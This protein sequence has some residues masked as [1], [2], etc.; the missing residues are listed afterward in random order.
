MKKQYQRAFW[1]AFLVGMSPLANSA[2]ESR[3]PS[4]DGGWATNVITTLSNKNKNIGALTPNQLSVLQRK[5][6]EAGIARELNASGQFSASRNLI[7]M[8]YKN[9]ASF[10]PAAALTY[11]RTFRLQAT[12]LNMPGLEDA[13]SEVAAKRVACLNSAD[14]FLLAQIERLEKQAKGEGISNDPTVKT[15]PSAE[16]LIKLLGIYSLERA[17]TLL[18]YGD[19]LYSSQPQSLFVDTENSKWSRHAAMSKYRQARM[20]LATASGARPANQMDDYL[21]QRRIA[22]QDKLRERRRW[23][24]QGL[25]FGGLKY[26]RNTPSIGLVN[27]SSP[28]SLAGK[29]KLKLDELGD[30]QSKLK[31]RIKTSQINLQDKLERLANSNL[32]EEKFATQMQSDLFREIVALEDRKGKHE[33]DLLKEINNHM[34]SLGKLKLVYTEG[35][36][37]LEGQISIEEEKVWK[38]LDG[39][40]SVIKDLSQI[41]PKSEIS[42]E[43]TT[44]ANLANDDSQKRVNVNILPDSLGA[45]A[46]FLAQSIEAHGLE[47]SAEKKNSIKNAI[48]SLETSNT[49]WAEIEN[50]LEKAKIKKKALKEK[51]KIEQAFLAIN[52]T[53]IERNEVETEIKF[54][55]E[56]AKEKYELVKDESALTTERKAADF[57]NKILKSEEA[58]FNKAKNRMESEI[59][60]V[61][62]LIN[63]ANEVVVAVQKGV[64]NVDAAVQAAQGIY[65]AM[66]GVP[67]GTGMTV[68]FERNTLVGLM[69]SA[70]DF[71]KFSYQA[72]QDVQVVKNKIAEFET[73][74]RD[75]KQKLEELSFKSIRVEVERALEVERDKLREIALKRAKQFEEKIKE[76]EKKVTDMSE[77]KYRLRNTADELTG[78]QTQAIKLEQATVDLEIANLK[79]KQSAINLE[80]KEQLANLWGSAEGLR[81]IYAQ[82]K[83]L[84]DHKAL[85]AAEYDK[86]VIRL[87]AGHEALVTLIRK[88]AELQQTRLGQVILTLDSLKKSAA[89][90]SP[91]GTDKEGVI[92][93][94]PSAS[95]LGIDYSVSRAIALGPIS[96]SNTLEPDFFTLWSYFEKDRDNVSNLLF[97][98]SNALTIASQD[99]RDLEW[100]GFVHSHEEAKFA[101]DE[102]DARYQKIRERKKAEQVRSMVFKVTKSDI[103]KYVIDQYVIGVD[104]NLETVGKLPPCLIQR[105]D[106][107]QPTD[108]PDRCL[109][110]RIAPSPLALGLT[111][112]GEEDDRKAVQLRKGVFV[113]DGTRDWDGFLFESVNEKINKG[114]VKDFE[115]IF[116]P[117]VGN[118]GVAPIMYNAFLSVKNGEGETLSGLRTVGGSSM[119]CNGLLKPR[120]GSSYPLITKD[121]LLRDETRTPFTSNPSVARLEEIDSAVRDNYSYLSLQKLSSKDTFLRGIGNV[122]EIR[123]EDLTKLPDEMHLVVIYAFENCLRTEGE[124]AEPVKQFTSNVQS[125]TETLNNQGQIIASNMIGFETS[126]S[127]YSK[128]LNAKVVLATAENE[129]LANP[130]NHKLNGKITEARSAL[131]P[132][133]TEGALRLQVLSNMNSLLGSIIHP[134]SSKERSSDKADQKAL[135]VLEDKW[136]DTY[137]PVLDS[138]IE[139]AAFIPDIAELTNMETKFGANISL[140]E[141]LDNPGKYGSFLRPPPLSVYEHLPRL[142]LSKPSGTPADLEGLLAEQLEKELKKIAE[143]NE[144]I[145]SVVDFHGRAVSTNKGMDRLLT[146][147]SRRVSWMKNLTV[148]LENQFEGGDAYRFIPHIACTAYAM[149]DFEYWLT[150]MGG[151]K[152]IKKLRNFLKWKSALRQK[153]DFRE[154][155]SASDAKEDSQRDLY[156]QENVDFCREIAVID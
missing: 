18:Q 102:M 43:W 5:V 53:N 138:W 118:D 110:I 25:F 127:A 107:P 147:G 48:E 79:A 151:G 61:Q 7:K 150:R 88:S 36:E 111:N 87:K 123:V 67:I 72:V 101:L 78:A 132:E 134:K 92:T 19:L 44:L 30:K 51:L 1:V 27:D 22:L 86:E 148:Q 129:S 39:F 40:L 49:R 156:A 3:C 32:D 119:S 89:E 71:A 34:D 12:G 63:Q 108:N 98:Y 28:S 6:E 141:A 93:S 69:D 146:L 95:P 20:S 23:F 94:A 82:I 139:T 73:S 14:E 103:E 58:L 143:I 70:T 135:S 15:K 125:L 64:Q 145:G 46:E 116:S 81:K 13:P 4:E 153:K 41:A 144:G 120:V 115:L 11:A 59:E 60:N 97:E 54:A 99:Y 57:K 24:Q 128:V 91:E 76:V 152:D 26:F 16:S 126:L 74:L 133:G 52:L 124:Q 75:Y 55:R 85:K 90:K 142:M 130:E 10:P 47:V 121:D 37:E 113:A 117:I 21:R 68:N 62:R 66:Q 122:F 80:I 31:E 136:A 84:N 104:E 137:L 131:P 100:G 2:E 105:R 29:A 45:I 114:G 83:T 149:E 50:E 109:R 106:S 77:I 112:K 155:L 65:T 9:E 96:R 33:Q 140:K 35:R 8:L 56:I 17:E 154:L 42:K 38:Q